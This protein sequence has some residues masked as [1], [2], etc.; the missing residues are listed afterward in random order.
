MKNL[1]Y[2][3]IQLIRF[4]PMPFVILVLAW[5]G[6]GL[7]TSLDFDVGPERMRLL[8]ILL[9]V[10]LAYLGLFFGLRPLARKHSP[11]SPGAKAKEPL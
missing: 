8:A 1:K 6:I 9:I 3:C 10:V 7:Y 2:I 4:L 5:G 11:R